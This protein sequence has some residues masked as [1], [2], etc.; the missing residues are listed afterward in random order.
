M[1]RFWYAYQCNDCG[2]MAP[3]NPDGTVAP[4]EGAIYTWPML[5]AEVKSMCWQHYGG[6]DYC[7]KCESKHRSENVQKPLGLNRGARTAL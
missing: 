2:D 5:R 4:V 6:N 3:K 1:R 7:P